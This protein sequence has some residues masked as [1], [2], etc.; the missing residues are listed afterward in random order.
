[1]NIFHVGVEFNVTILKQ[2]NKM[3][4]NASK[5]IDSDTYEKIT[6]TTK[7]SVSQEEEKT[8]VKDK[9]TDCEGKL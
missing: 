2:I 5:S 1:M 9:H 4:C 7:N 6:N 8:N 3:G